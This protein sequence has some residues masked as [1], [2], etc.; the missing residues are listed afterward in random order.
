MKN[1]VRVLPL[2]NIPKKYSFREPSGGT[3]NSKQ[4]LVSYPSFR[5]NSY[6]SYQYTTEIEVFKIGL[7]YHLIDMA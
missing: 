1:L 2:N 4:I 3:H 5:Q 6:T 7:T